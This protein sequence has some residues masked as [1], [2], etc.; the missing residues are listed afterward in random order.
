MDETEQST[1]YVESK[2]L[3]TELKINQ[4]FS[5]NLLNHIVLILFIL[6]FNICIYLFIWLHCIL[7]AACG[8]FVTACRIFLVAA[9]RIF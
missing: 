1:V 6:F 4:A 7:A 5:L 8:I 2:V 3:S 9:C